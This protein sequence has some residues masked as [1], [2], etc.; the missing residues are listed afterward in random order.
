[1]YKITVL[2]VAVLFVGSLFAQTD[3][4]I[5][6]VFPKEIVNS[7]HSAATGGVT[8]YFNFDV[9]DT[10]NVVEE[11]PVLPLTMSKTFYSTNNQ[12]SYSNINMTVIG[13]PD[14]DNTYQGNFALPAVAN[15]YFYH[16]V[17]TE[18]TF[19]S[20]SPK[21]T[22]DVFPAPDNKMANM[23]DD[24]A[25]DNEPIV[26]DAS[27]D[28]S[29]TD[30][31]NFKLSYSD[32]RMYIEMITDGGLNTSHTG[33]KQLECGWLPDK[34]AD[35]YH[36]YGI[37][38]INPN[39]P[40]PDSIIYAVIYADL[41][42]TFLGMGI[43][44]TPGVYKIVVP[45]EGAGIPDYLD[46]FTKISTTGTNYNYNTSGANLNMWFNLDLLTSDPD[47]GPLRDDSLIVSGCGIGS[48][49][50]A[51]KSCYSVVTDTF[52]YVVNDFSKNCAYYMKTGFEPLGN[53]TAPYFTAHDTSTSGT[54]YTFYVTYKDDENN[55]PTMRR[56]H[57]NVDG[58]PVG[59]S[60]FTMYSSD[61]TYD[62]GAQYYCT[63]SIVDPS[64]IIYRFQFSDG[65]FEINLTDTIL[66]DVMSF[67]TEGDTFFILDL[68]FSNTYAMDYRRAGEPF[69]V[70]NNGTINIDFG[71]LITAIDPAGSWAPGYYQDSNQYV[72][73]ARFNQE[74][75]A[76]EFQPVAD[77]IMDGATK[78]ATADLFGPEGSDIPPSPTEGSSNNFW[79]QFV[80][81]TYSD[82]VDPTPVTIEVTVYVRQHIP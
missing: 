11:H 23:H 53:N 65:E 27:H 64:I 51:Y 81:P 40:Y 75:T 55:Q 47:F 42:I 52:N 63:R 33:Q 31:R 50:L 15:L 72:L 73:R 60:P 71:L 2:F 66:F 82:F 68:P 22:G 38:V 62:D 26:L 1:M 67:N 32:T 19:S 70:T 41:N 54:N 80:A 4:G 34:Y 46:A 3:F 28:W 37:P 78:W 79:L 29:N 44:I 8:L 24:P 9:I 59:G 20:T 12:T 16:Q 57:L 69:I 5:P 14:Y 76:G 61:R 36:I 17:A 74:T 77:L 7:R 10:Y 30:L 39:A 49:W 43:I 18:S 6:S 56:M 21:N 25:G 13:A 45:G 35:V 48:A 58:V